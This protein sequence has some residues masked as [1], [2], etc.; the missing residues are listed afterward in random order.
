M[1]WKNP[2]RTRIS[3]INAWS[4]LKR[5]DR[6]DPWK[7]NED[8]ILLENTSS[9]TS[10]VDHSTRYSI[11]QSRPFSGSSNGDFKLGADGT[12]NEASGQVQDNTF[13]TILSALPVFTLITSATGTA[14]KSGAASNEPANEVKF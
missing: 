9:L 8:R 7:Q 5:K 11:N 6:F 1:N 4:D 2:R 10:V 13:S 12:L 3:V 14:T